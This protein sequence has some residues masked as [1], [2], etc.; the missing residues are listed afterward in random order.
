MAYPVTLVKSDDLSG[1]HLYRF[2]VIIL[3]AGNYGDV[4]TDNQLTKFQEW[5]RAGGRMI[6]VEGAARFLAGKDGFGLKPPDNEE[7]VDEGA[8]EPSVQQYSERYR[9]DITESITGAIFSADLDISHPLAFGYDSPYFTLKHNSTAYPCLKKDGML[10]WSVREIRLVDSREAK[11]NSLAKT[12]FCLV[13]SPLEGGEVVYLMD[14]PIYRGFW[15]GGRL[16]L[17]NAVFLTGQRS[18]SSF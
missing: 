11:Q 6:A 8:E 13:L 9:L 16:L 2:D 12:P 3:P 1:L 10:A 18:V 4:L 7:D 15:Y 17:A 14:N 5:L